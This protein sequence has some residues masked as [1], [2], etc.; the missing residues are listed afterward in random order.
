[1]GTRIEPK[2]TL[3]REG[4]NGQWASMTQQSLHS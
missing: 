4:R 1:M 2:K 3:T